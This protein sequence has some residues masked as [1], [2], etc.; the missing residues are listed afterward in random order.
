MTIVLGVILGVEE[1]EEVVIFGDVEGEEGEDT[2]GLI[3]MTSMTLM[4]MNKKHRLLRAE[5][6]FLKYKT[7]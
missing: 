1:E 2:A 4:D 7:T 6:S 5:V 3:W